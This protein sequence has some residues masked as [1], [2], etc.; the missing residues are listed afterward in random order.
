MNVATKRPILTAYQ[1]SI[2]AYWNNKT[3]DGVNLRLGE[4]DGIYHHHYGLGPYDPELLHAPKP[5]RDDEIIKELHR[6]ETAQANVLL[7]QFGDVAETDRLLDA[8][9]GRGGTSILARER[10]G[11][12]VDGVT[13][14]EYQVAFAREKANA[15]GHQDHVR[16]HLRN[17][18]D[19]GFPSGS[20]R[21][22]WT[23]ETTMYVDLFA[24]F[25]EFARLLRAGGRYVCITGCY[26]DVIGEKSPAVRTIDKHYL[27]DV[28]PRSRYFKALAASHLVP[29]TVIDLTPQT[30]PYWELRAQSSLRTGIE[31]PFLAGYRDGSFQYLLIAADRARD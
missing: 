22:I 25:D 20:F 13:I 14:S 30:M 23:N 27:C 11:C 7:D 1:Q 3:Q 4:V 8:G 24:L 6:L 16:F 10:F 18:L 17:M 12:S 28:H 21:G 5:G 19:T 26:N 29:G 2:A 31:E 9:C 15:R